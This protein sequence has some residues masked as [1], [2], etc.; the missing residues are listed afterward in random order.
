MRQRFLCLHPELISLPRHP[1]LTPAQINSMSTD[2]NYK[3]LWCDDHAKVTE[4]YLGLTDRHEYAFFYA[5][6][7]NTANRSWE[8]YS[9]GRETKKRLDVLGQHIVGCLDEEPIPADMLIETLGRYQ[10]FIGGTK[11]NLK[12][13][14]L[15]RFDKDDPPGQLS[16]RSKYIEMF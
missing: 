6:F 14:G 1:N 9:N 12:G 15:I 16:S 11:A 10:K 3:W 7:I 8:I 13:T 4:W 2:V 5:S